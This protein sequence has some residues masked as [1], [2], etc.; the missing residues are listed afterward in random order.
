MRVRAS[1]GFF[2]IL[3]VLG[4]AAGGFPAYAGSLQ[5][6]LRDGLGNPLPAPQA[7]RRA[8]PEDVAAL[9]AAVSAPNELNPNPLTQV[10][11]LRA[12]QVSQQTSVYAVPSIYDS[13][14]KNG[15]PWVVNP[16]EAQP[17]SQPA[18]PAESKLVLDHIED[19]QVQV[20]IY[21]RVEGDA[22]Q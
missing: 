20:P 4:N 3:F 14:Y 11:D 22:A 21:K 6:Q 12:A 16:P 8:D 15:L 2:P 5:V 9:T 13:P 19:Q 1:F 10:P 7:S 17:P 18:R